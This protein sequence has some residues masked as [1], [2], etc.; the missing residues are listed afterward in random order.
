MTRHKAGGSNGESVLVSQLQHGLTLEF[1]NSDPLRSLRLTLSELL[2]IMNK[3]PIYIIIANSSDN[4]NSDGR[5]LYDTLK[6]MLIIKK[7]FVLCRY[8]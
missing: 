6:V 1:E 8:K 3:V 5:L 7:Y 4:M 2:V